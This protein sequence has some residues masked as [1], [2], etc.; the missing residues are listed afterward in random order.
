MSSTHHIDVI[1]KG[2][3]SEYASIVSVVESKFGEMDLDEV[4]ILLLAHEL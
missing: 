1:L 4:E 2:L 3:P